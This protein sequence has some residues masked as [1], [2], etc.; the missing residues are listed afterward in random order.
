MRAEG[1]A[2]GRERD[3]G[4][5]GRGRQAKARAVAAAARVEE[6]REAAP[7]REERQES[8]RAERE[9]WAARIAQLA[10]KHGLQLQDDLQVVAGAE[11]QQA[12]RLELRPKGQREQLEVFRHGRADEQGHHHRSRPGSWA[13][14]DDTSLT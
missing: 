6:V 10:S 2:I 7:R 9:G 5:A 8:R 11:L 4:R 14:T 12:W 13:D 1:G 3:R